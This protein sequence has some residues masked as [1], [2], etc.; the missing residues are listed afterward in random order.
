MIPSVIHR[1]HC[2]FMFPNGGIIDELVVGHITD[3]RARYPRRTQRAMG[4]LQS[5]EEGLGLPAIE[6]ALRK[7]YGPLCSRSG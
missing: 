4:Y 3:E 1:R 5:Q 6:E 7:D 2:S